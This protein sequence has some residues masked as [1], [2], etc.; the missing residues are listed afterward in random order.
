MNAAVGVGMPNS[1]TAAAVPDCWRF[2]RGAMLVRG[3]IE[4]VGEAVAICVWWLQTDRAPASQRIVQPI[5]I[6]VDKVIY[7]AIAVSV[8]ATG[9]DEI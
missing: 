6:E 8:V 7:H 2:A 5:M 3:R 1:A 9:F 4:K